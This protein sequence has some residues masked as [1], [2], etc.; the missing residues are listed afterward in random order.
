MSEKQYQVFISYSTIDSETAFSLLRVLEDYG[1]RCWIAP[2][3]IP[4]GAVWADAIDR[5]IQESQCFVVIVSSNSISSKQ[6]PKEVALAVTSCEGIFPFRIDK[7]ALEGSFRYYLSD[8]QFVDAQQERE[9]KMKELACAI[10]AA[11]KLPPYAPPKAAVLSQQAH[12]A[13]APETFNQAPP[14]QGF[15]EMNNAKNA[16]QK[17]PD[18]KVKWKWLPFLLGLLILTMAVTIPLILTRH[19]SNTTE[20]TTEAAVETKLPSASAAETELPNA[21]VAE[22]EAPTAEP[23]TVMPAGDTLTDPSPLF[24]RW[25]QVAEMHRGDDLRLCF[26]GES[27]L[28]FTVCADGVVFTSNSSYYQQLG[29]EPARLV[30]DA[31]G[32]NF[33]EVFVPAYNQEAYKLTSVCFLQ[34]SFD[35]TIPAEDGDIQA[36]VY[37]AKDFSGVDFSSLTWQDCYPDRYLVIHITGTYQENPVS[38]LPIDTWMVFQKEYPNFGYA[39]NQTLVGVWDDNR[40]NEWTFWPEE[41]DILFSIKTMDGTT[42]PGIYFVDYAGVQ[43]DALFYEQMTFSFSDFSLRNY[44]VLYFDGNLL[45]MLDE[46]NQLFSLT[47]K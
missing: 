6:V 9:E 22:T 10:R 37:E 15:A 5:G 25:N 36:P 17:A 34:D 2:R 44:A 27:F 18:K 41:N 33:T 47:R 28:E 19:N 30:W 11:L 12:P 43:E 45:F 31:D 23:L 16:Q 20:R 32:V 40:G 4:Q 21:S 24:G 7:S 29:R 35:G 1:L 46:Q 3:D 8:Y 42:Y 39:R 26:N 14:A 13:A 38:T